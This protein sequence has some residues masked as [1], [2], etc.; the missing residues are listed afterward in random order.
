MKNKFEV[1]DKVVL[2]DYEKMCEDHKV[3]PDNES[4]KRHYSYLK[5]KE[6]LEIHYIYPPKSLNYSLE[7]CDRKD[8][9]GKV[10]EGYLYNCHTPRSKMYLFDETDLIKYEE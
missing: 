6:P 2:I 5:N 9:R 4:F 3:S 7:D 8:L 1:G 10:N